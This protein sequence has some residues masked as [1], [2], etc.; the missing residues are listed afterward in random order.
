MVVL[1]V[2]FHCNVCLGEILTKAWLHFADSSV[3]KTE[4]YTLPGRRRGHMGP[5]GLAGNGRRG[6][7]HSGKCLCGS[8]G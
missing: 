5:T 6:G 2:Q 1:G 8:D 4:R 7:Q 3:T